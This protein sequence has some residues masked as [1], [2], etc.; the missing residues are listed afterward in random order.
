MHLA[1][2]TVPKVG[3]CVQVGIGE[4]VL[5]GR[6]WVVNICK[7]VAV[8]L[9]ALLAPLGEAVPASTEVALGSQMPLGS[10][11]IGWPT[12]RCVVR[13]AP[14]ALSCTHGSSVLPSVGA[15]ENNVRLEKKV[16]E[17]VLEPLGCSPVRSSAAAERLMAPGLR[18]FTNYF[19]ACTL[20]ICKLLIRA[21][22][23]KSPREIEAKLRH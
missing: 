4:V 5:L 9:G 7:E 16:S 23:E 17:W 1:A 19:Q 22:R 10:G 2:A 6:T 20:D 12:P 14:L 21:T 15:G 3:C 11:A 13:G 18:S 8:I